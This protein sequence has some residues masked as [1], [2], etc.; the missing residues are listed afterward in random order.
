MK[1]LYHVEASWRNTSGSTY[2]VSAQPVQHIVL[3]NPC[4]EGLAEAAKALDTDNE[5]REEAGAFFSIE[6]V[7]LIGPVVT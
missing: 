1:W 2:V 5:R 3:D 6:K 7:T 4:C